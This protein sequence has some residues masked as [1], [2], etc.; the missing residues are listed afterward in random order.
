MKVESY[1]VQKVEGCNGEAYG[2]WDV[3]TRYWYN[4]EVDGTERQQ[5]AAEAK[6]HDLIRYTIKGIEG[7]VRTGKTTPEQASKN[8]VSL[9]EHIEAIHSSRKILDAPLR[10]DLF[11]VVMSTELAK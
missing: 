5:Y 11:R 2:M 6:L 4:I 1:K 8:L 3:E 9:L 10:A 7:S